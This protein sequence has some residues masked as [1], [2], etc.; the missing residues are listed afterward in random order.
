[1]EISEVTRRNIFDELSVGNVNWCGRLEEPAFLGRMYDLNDLPSHDF[2]YRAAAR[3]IHQHCVNNHDWPNDWVFSDA[4]FNLHHCPGEEL[5]RFFCEMM[6]PVVRQ[7]AKEVAT[8]LDLFNRHLSA[9]GWEL[10]EQSRLS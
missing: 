9:D 1:M 10:Y 7:D 6:H 5:L 3:D 2:R 4:R 8:L